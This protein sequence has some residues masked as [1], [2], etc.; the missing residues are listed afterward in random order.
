[1]KKLLLLFLLV[2]ICALSQNS[3]EEVPIF[4][5]CESKRNKKKCFDK[6][7]RQHIL[8]FFYYPKEA[9]V[10]KEE[11]RVYI[12]F[13]INSDGDISSVK[14]RA[15]YKS[16]KEAAIKIISR[17]SSNKFIPGK[18]DGKNVDVPFTIPITFRLASQSC[19]L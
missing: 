1:M 18:V 12:Q 19:E 11:G 6:K 7:L 13:I 17:L 5:G 9:I 14:A 3:S 4:P 16:L 8:T 2:P 15:P 10:R